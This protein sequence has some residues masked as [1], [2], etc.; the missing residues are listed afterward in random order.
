MTFW[1][2]DPKFEHGLPNISDANWV[3]IQIEVVS[4]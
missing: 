2:I 1:K 4:K 3:Q